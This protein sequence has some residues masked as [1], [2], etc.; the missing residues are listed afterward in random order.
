MSPPRKLG[1]SGYMCNKNLGERF[2]EPYVRHGV[3][4]RSRG[5]GEQ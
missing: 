4:G 1:Y 5:E 3:S 2:R